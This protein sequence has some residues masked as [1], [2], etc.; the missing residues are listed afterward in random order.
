MFIILSI[1]FIVIIDGYI[2]IVEYIELLSINAGLVLEEIYCRS[3]IDD[4]E[5]E[6]DEW[7]VVYCIEEYGRRKW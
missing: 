7:L 3:G 2:G 4:D 1:P 5:E 6:C